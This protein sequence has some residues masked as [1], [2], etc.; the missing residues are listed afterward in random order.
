VPILNVKGW[1][2]VHYVPILNVKGWVP[3]ALSMLRKPDY[4]GACG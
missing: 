4:I 2:H 1:V 3:R